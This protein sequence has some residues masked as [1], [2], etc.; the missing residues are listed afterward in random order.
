MIDV[1]VDSLMTGRLIN[2]A[3]ILFTDAIFVAIL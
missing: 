2:L 1:I 3:L